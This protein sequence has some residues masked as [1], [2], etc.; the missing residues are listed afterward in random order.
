LKRIEKR[1]ESTESNAKQKQSK[2]K[3][4][5]QR[6]DQ[7]PS[8]ADGLP[9]SSRGGSWPLTEASECDIGPSGGGDNGLRSNE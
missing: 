5:A 7:Y 3:K 8:D 4:D 2:K 1:I 9:D 6:G